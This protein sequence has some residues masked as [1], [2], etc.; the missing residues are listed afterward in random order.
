MTFRSI[1]HI[2]VDN[3]SKQVLVQKASCQSWFEFETCV[4]NDAT[5]KQKVLWRRNTLQVTA[6]QP[7]R[8]GNSKQSIYFHVVLF[9]VP[10][11]QKAA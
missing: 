8:S 3:C 4:G 5:C 2:I 9:D 1:H 11:L 7:T 6:H 10:P